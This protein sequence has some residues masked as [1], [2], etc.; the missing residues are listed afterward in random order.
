[1]LN[2]WFH[3]VFQGLNASVVETAPAQFGSSAI[4]GATVAEPQEAATI[5][6]AKGTHPADAGYMKVLALQK[7][8]N[9]RRNKGDF[10]WF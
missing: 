7:E 8:W 5:A 10:C 4:K 1:M 6:S 9:V 3:G 2:D